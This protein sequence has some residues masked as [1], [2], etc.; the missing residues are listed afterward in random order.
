MLTIQTREIRSC[1][2][3][4]IAAARRWS[5]QPSSEGGPHPS[6]VLLESLVALAHRRPC[7]R[8]TRGAHLIT[9]VCATRQIRPPWRGSSPSCMPPETIQGRPDSRPDRRALA[10]RPAGQR[11]PRARRERPRCE[12]RRD[13][14]PT[15]Q[16]RQAPRGRD[17]PLGLG[18]TRALAHAAFRPTGR[19]VVLH[20]ARP[21]AR[22][23]MGARRRSHPTSRG[24]PSRGR[25]AAP[26]AAPAA[27]CA[28]GEMHA[29]GCRCS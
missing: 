24:Q 10:R 26:R 20:L 18:S 13:P 25:Q 21:H 28:R 1:G 22:A 14:G 11:G 6:T 5:G 15:W 2:A 9:R 23:A 7:P 4:A 12:Q 27:P 29:R 16:G 19:R 3:G 8:S 17:G